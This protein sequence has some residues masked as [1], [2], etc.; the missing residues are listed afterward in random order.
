MGMFMDAD[1]AKIAEAIRR[2]RKPI[3]G[4]KVLAAGHL[5]PKYALNY[6]AQQRWI[7]IIALGVAS[8]KEAEETLS[9]AATAFSGMINV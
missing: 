7:D 8:E 2:L 3:I 5:P 6:V 1:P 4:K 9:A